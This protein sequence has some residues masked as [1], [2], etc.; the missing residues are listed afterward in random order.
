MQITLEWS[1]VIS[2]VSL[3]VAAVKVVLAIVKDRKQNISQESSFSTSV[4]D[5]LNNISSDLQ[6]LK[7]DI[8]DVKSDVSSHAERIA[9]LE[10]RLDQITA[11]SRME[12]AD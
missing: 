9:K 5:K 2:V 11:V 10:A 4:M 7:R 8:R 6:E 1:I 12:N 3:C